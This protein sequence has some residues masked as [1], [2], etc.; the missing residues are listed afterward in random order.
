MRKFAIWI[1]SSKKSVT[2]EYRPMS[3]L[4]F[5]RAILSRN[6]IHSK[7]VVCNCTWVATKPTLMSKRVYSPFW[8]PFHKIGQIVKR[9]LF[10]WF[11][12][13]YVDL[14]LLICNKAYW[15][16][17]YLQESIIGITRS[18]VCYAICCSSMH[19]RLGCIQRLLR[20]IKSSA[21]HRSQK[22][23]RPKRQREM[24]WPKCT[25]LAKSLTSRQF[26]CDS[27][28]CTTF[29]RSDVM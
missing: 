2:Q 12:S 18:R 19:A 24:R 20:T 23:G 15:K 21:W 29:L 13:F 8:P 3:H 28:I 26:S 17:K 14:T 1:P 16:L 10:F 4:R 6:L 11:S 25:V 27:T 5:L 22:A 9:F 7:I